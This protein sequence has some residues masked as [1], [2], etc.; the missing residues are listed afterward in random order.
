LVVAV[1]KPWLL[2]TIGKMHHFV[3]LE[4]FEGELLVGGKKRLNGAFLEGLCP[5]KFGGHFFGKGGLVRWGMDGVE[6][7][8]NYGLSSLHNLFVGIFFPR[9]DC[10]ISFVPFLR[11]RENPFSTEKVV[12]HVNDGS[13]SMRSFL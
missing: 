5:K 6:P 2:V 13:K 7:F 11:T 8:S 1:I 4:G 10:V 9:G 12:L 3:N